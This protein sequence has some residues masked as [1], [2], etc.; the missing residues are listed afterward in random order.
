MHDGF[1]LTD[2]RPMVRQHASDLCI[3]GVEKKKRRPRPNGA[4]RERRIR[5]KRDCADRAIPRSALWP[6]HGTRE[7]DRARAGEAPHRPPN[8]REVIECASFLEL[9]TMLHENTKVFNQRNC[10]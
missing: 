1:I 3:S 5:G 8:S 4:G 9:L 6:V 7:R 10:A 2:L